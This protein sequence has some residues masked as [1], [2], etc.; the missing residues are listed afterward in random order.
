[1]NIA[2]QGNG[3]V[4]R[5]APWV[6]LK[7]DA[8]DDVR[9]SAFAGLA[10]A[11]RML[12]GIAITIQPFLPGA[13]R[14][15][16]MQGHDGEVS[17]VLWDDAV[18]M[19]ETIPASTDEPTPLFER[20]DIKAILEREGRWRRLSQDEQPQVGSVKVDVAKKEEQ[21]MEREGIGTIE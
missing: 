3:V 12:K 14:L 11:A 10:L 16:S 9:A 13:Q 8:S 5:A 17:E 19:S 20:L 15:W 6:A 4:Q 7:P 21:T 18:D 2:Q 1:M